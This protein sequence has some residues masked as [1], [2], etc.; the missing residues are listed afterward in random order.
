MAPLDL[1]AGTPLEAL[2]PSLE[3]APPALAIPAYRAWLAANAASPLAFAA[4]FNLGVQCAAA[5]DRAGAIEAYRQALA[6]KPDLHQAAVNLGLALEASGEAE[7]ALAAWQGALQPDEARLLLLNHSGRLLEGQ[8]RYAEAEQALRASLL[9]DPRQPDVVQHWSHIRQKSCLW[10]L[11]AP[12]IPGV[13]ARDLVLQSG[14]LGI[15]ALTDDVALQREVTAAWIARK[16]PPAPARLAPEGGYRHDRIRVGY[17]SSDFCRH[18]M[19]TLIVELLERH[20]RG[21]FEVF[22]YCSTREDGSAL[23]Q[24]IIAALDHHVP[25]GTLSEEAA[26]RRIR[27]DEIDILV[28]LNG[29]TQGAR[30]GALR[31]KPAPVQATYLG[32]VGPVPLPELDWLICDA[33]V[34]PPDQAMHYA[35]R[36]L[37][38][39]GLYQANDSRA[40]ALPALT[41]REE[42]LP[43]D[44]FVLCCFNNFYKITE[45]VF[46]AWLEILHRLPHAVLWLAEDNATG[47]E[48]LRRHAAARGIA[49]DRLIVAPR[50]EP[51]RYLARLGLAD[52]FLDT[53]PYN[54]GTVASDA[55]RMG[56]PLVTLSGRSFASRMAGA[57]LQAVGLPDCIATTLDGYMA[58]AVAHGSDPARHARARAVLAG[59]EAWRRSI[60]DSAGFTARMEAA[61]EAIRLRP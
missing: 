42:G 55:L 58:T 28:D 51:A 12:G 1:A 2:L 8:K 21:R 31:W 26:A 20:D 61:L 5:G 30:L 16:V 50:A 49:P 53:F 47:E 10:P 60:G 56:L 9:T 23:R 52:L 22:G 41:R 24:R 59:G 11:H 37:P 39:A 15:L 54:A 4:W 46:G 43:E 6:R 38:L 35:P 19:G 36:P 48:T 13:A 29:L 17:L 33:Q 3:G 44:A 57:L 32:Y 45:D 34:V 7:A 40:P 18:A 25:I 14:P 27:A